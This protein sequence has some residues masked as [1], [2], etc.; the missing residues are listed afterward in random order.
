MQSTHRFG[1]AVFV[2]CILAWCL[3]VYNVLH[4]IAFP[5]CQWKSSASE[6]KSAY[7]LPFKMEHR[8]PVMAVTPTYPVALCEHSTV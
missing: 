4:G 8:V 7:S 6:S 3:S 5:T 2:I 1:Q